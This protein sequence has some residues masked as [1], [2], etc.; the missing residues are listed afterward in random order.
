[1][2][3]GGGRLLRMRGGHSAPSTYI[4]FYGEQGSLLSAGQ[5]SSVRVFSSENDAASR[6]LGRADSGGR[7]LPPVVALAA[8]ELSSHSPLPTLAPLHFAHNRNH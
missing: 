3:D 2:P 1:M 5:D 8:G 4:R 7:P 6:S